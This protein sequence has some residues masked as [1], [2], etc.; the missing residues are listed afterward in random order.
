MTESD[1]GQRLEFGVRLPGGPD[2]AATVRLARAAEELGLD[3]VVV[4]DRPDRP[5]AE[6]WTL[7][8]WIA[9]VTDTVRLGTAGH[10]GAAR[11][12]AVL[13]RTAAGLD[14]LSGGRVELGITVGEPG[15]DGAETIDVV[16]G[17]WDVLEHGLARVDG[18]RHRL[19]GAQRAAPAHDVPITVSGPDPRD[20]DLARLAGLRADGWSVPL[21]G[22][23]DLAAGRL[24]VDAAAREAGRDPREIR[25]W[26]TVPPAGADGGAATLL[27]L[28]VEH[29]VGTIVLDPG[30][31]RDAVAALT[32]FARDVVPTVRAGADAALPHGAGGVRVRRSSALARRR[33]GIDYDGVPA[34]PVAVEPGDLAYARLRG[35]YLRGGSPGIV[36][37][38]ATVEQVVDALAF[39]R[40]HPD[41]PLSRRSAGHGLS[42]RS[43]ND[44]GIVI[45]VSPMNAVEV[46]DE[47]ERR[48]R[49]GPGARWTDVA[50]A[51]ARYGWAISSGD[52]G[53]VGV[54]GLATAGGIG[55]LARG[56]GLTI[57]RLRAVE[58]VLSDGSVVRAGD[59]E[60]P[61]LFWAVRGAGANFGIVTA[62][63]FVADEVGPVA[64]AALT[65]VVPDVAG[66]LVEWGRVVEESPR[67]LTGF[68]ILPPPDGRRPA[69]AL[70]RTVVESADPDTV[71]ARL[72]PLAGLA[73]MYEQQVAITSYA[74]IM[75]NASD[76]APV[77]RGEPVSRSGLVHHLTPEFAAVAARV[78]RS[79]AV[80]WFQLRSVGGAVADVAP[81]ATAY[82]HRSPN[83]SLVVM[84]SDPDAVD[85]QWASLTPFLDGLYLSFD[86]SLRPERIQQAWPAHTLARL[87]ALK[88][89]YD[90]DG[91]FDDNF[92]L[93][94]T[95][96]PEASPR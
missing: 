18:P 37:R 33:P 58:M 55:Y 62:F 22:A 53:G 87:R 71:L 61:D 82:P 48:V 79:G 77:S 59:T 38:A 81:D 72:Q 4:P 14:H 16:A 73:P 28:V 64:F 15:N 51:L 95:P 80:H 75:A 31:G 49:I 94:P 23:D 66:Y 13:A 52:Y 68:L 10:D 83:F 19:A 84:G 74:D 21:A 5:D 29:G 43:T 85:A 24:L 17:L 93:T 20:P 60:N 45:D 11:N 12:P 8:A 70:T 42:G 30:P 41:L 26:V 27:D 36:L 86:T 35:G 32:R 7:L 63:E 1:Y 39:A 89:T 9:A 78:L 91:V 90:P 47:A 65:Q 2:P 46:L 6:A 54:G 40:R 96:P 92:A 88:A 69:V 25:R 67:D 76:D 44:G 50:T 56:H 3:L 57:D 34:G